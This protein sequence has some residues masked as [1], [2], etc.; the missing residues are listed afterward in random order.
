[1]GELL[2]IGD[3][4]FAANPGIAGIVGWS[5]E[6][7]VSSLSG[8][9]TLLSRGEIAIVCPGHGRLI[10]VPDAARMLV[11]VRTDALALANIA[12]LNRERAVQAAA[13][14]ED[15]MEQVNELFTIMAGRLYYVSYVMDELGES[16]I[17][18]EMSTLING[19]VVDELLDAFS[20]FAEEHHRGKN[21]S[22]HLALKAGQVIGKLERSFRKE[23]LSHIIEPSLVHRAERLLSDYTTMF[24]GFAPPKEITATDLPSLIEA[25]VAG[26]SIPACSDDDVMSSADD[27]AAFA[28]I[29][30][31]RIGTKPLLDDVGFTMHGVPGPVPVAIDRDHFNDLLTYILEDLVGTGSD[32]IGMAVEL[33]EPTVTITVSGNASAS[34][35]QGSQKNRRFLSGLCERAGGALSW[36]QDEAGTR[37]YSIRITRVI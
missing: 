8:I 23:D 12:E 15:C 18:E 32:Q 33:T 17:A 11:A 37:T 36:N 30:L 14:A 2:F 4:L 22:I 7:L 9:E 35:T 21:L 6:A 20:T 25:L 16:E 24:R 1:M 26:L 13:F 27:D 10:P 34:G 31:A 3:T 28:Q 19:D 5:Q 29:L